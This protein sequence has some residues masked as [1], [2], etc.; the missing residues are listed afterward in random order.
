MEKLQ[1]SYSINCKK[2]RS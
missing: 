2:N 1:P